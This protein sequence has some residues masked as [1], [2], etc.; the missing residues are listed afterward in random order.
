MTLNANFRSGRDSLLCAGS[1][2]SRF[3]GFGPLAFREAT[4]A[5][6][7]KEAESEEKQSTKN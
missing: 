2:G 6:E 3:A 1:A 7:G 4:E 5:E